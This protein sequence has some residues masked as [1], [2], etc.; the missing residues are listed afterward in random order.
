[1]ELT[2]EKLRNDY[3]LAVELFNDKK[4][5]LFLRNV[6]TAI[7]QLSM[8]IIY[9]LVDDEDEARDIIDG[10][11]SLQWNKN[12]NCYDIQDYPAKYKPSG[13]DYSLLMYRVFISKH[14]DYCTNNADLKKKEIKAAMN[15]YGEGLAGLYSV[16]S[17]WS[18]PESCN[19]SAYSQSVCTAAYIESFIDFLN[20]KKILSQSYI[21]T[22]LSFNKFDFS[23]T[24][25]IESHEGRILELNGKIHDL[26]ETL[27]DRN[28]IIAEKNSKI[29]D[30]EAQNLS[31]VETEGR[32]ISLTQDLE[33]F[34][35]K[36]ADDIASYQKQLAEKD[37]EISNLNKEVEKCKQECVESKR[38]AEEER[39][40]KIE[41]E[42]TIAQMQENQTS[43]EVEE[44]VSLDNLFD[45]A[46]ETDEA[47]EQSNIDL[48]DLFGDAEDEN[49]EEE[50][51]NDDTTEIED[52]K[53]PA[54]RRVLYWVNQ[55]MTA[56]QI[57][58]A[59]KAKPQNTYRRLAVLVEKGHADAKRFIS[60]DLYEEI[61]SAINEAGSSAEKQEIKNYCSSR[62]ALWQI[63][64]VL[65]ELKYK[66]ITIEP[67][68]W[69]FVTGISHKPA[70]ASKW[71]FK[72][73]HK[74]RVVRSLKGYYLQVGNEYIKLGNYPI[75]IDPDE[76]S[77]W[78]MGFNVI[79]KEIVHDTGIR[80]HLIG[81]IRDEKNRIVF[82]TPNKD[83]KYITFG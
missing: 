74:C 6:R 50:S 64:L 22:L 59:S 9:D 29:K 31:S 65:A 83:E 33:E 4:Y 18:H 51:D 26:E 45:I 24:K 70:K 41:L 14:E 54:L 43:E 34:K 52:I 75:D 69:K 79:G 13:R 72:T 21:A 57:R 30:L 16:T 28:V 47:N 20:N 81:Y 68:K 77:I 27:N 61:I 17:E 63:S 1:M 10:N 60:E 78:L 80:K 39:N 53:D 56:T 66:G 32:I 25:E 19:L 40:A 35:S 8:Y 37:T 42:A 46:E 3:N 12:K 58:D 82:T 38:K 76:G 36:Y 49:N 7:S 48:F 2:K 67:N 55:G 11:I 23:N 73:T 5:A 71:L 15:G 44:E 62:V